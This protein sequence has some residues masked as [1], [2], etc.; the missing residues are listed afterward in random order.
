MSKSRNRAS[1]PQ[2]QSPKGRTTKSVPVIHPDAAGIDIGSRSHFVA[3]PA[4]R[5]AEPVREFGCFTPDLNAMADWLLACG[6]RTVAMESTGVYWIPTFQILERRGL[7]VRLVNARHVKNVP[8]RK[9]DVLDCQWLQQ[10][11]AYGLLE[12]SFRPPD[13]VCVM[14]TL[15]RQRETLVQARSKQVQHMQKA[16]I[17]M[18][19]QLHKVV[20]DITGV[21]GMAIIRAILRGERDGATLAR[22]KHPNA[23]S[24]QEQIAKA[25]TGD[26]RAEH[27]FCLRQAVEAY[28]FHQAQIETC[29]AEL[30]AHMRTIEGEEPKAEASAPPRRRKGKPRPYQPQFDQ[31]G[32]LRRIAGVD[33]T[34]ID[35][36]ETMTA[37]TILAEVGWDVSRFPSEKHF[38]SWLGLCPDNRITGGRTVRSGTRK[39]MNRAAAAL[40]MAAQSLHRSQ[41]ALG[42]YYRRM[43]ARLG[44][45]KAITAAANKLARIV[46]RMLKHGQAYVDRGAD[47]YERE[48]RARAVQ[49]LQ[50]Q[51]HRLGFEVIEASTA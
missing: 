37:Q 6:V 10:L 38:C 46:Y 5:A 45:P 12:G 11:H 44:A 24:S 15:W 16:M 14:R 39:V 27:L 2:R 8:G 32:S 33:L 47:Y 41:S 3:V 18:N 13:E 43:R 42:A 4:D 35:G 48:Y 50:R 36:I 30:E 29:D 49:N 20:T 25:L 28:D 31:A 19:L 26:W 7:E 1:A 9:S 51:A 21:T 23:R 34:R 40:R 17:Q 22:L